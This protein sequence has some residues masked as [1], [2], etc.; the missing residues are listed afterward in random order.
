[1]FI[2]KKCPTCGWFC[3]EEEMEDANTCPYYKSGE[4]LDLEDEENE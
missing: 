2:T 3:T 4:Y 1:M